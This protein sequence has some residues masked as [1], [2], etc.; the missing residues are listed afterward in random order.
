[1]YFGRDG[2]TL[3]ILLAGG[4]KRRERQDIAAAQ[5]RWADYRRRRKEGT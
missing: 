4:T 1:V 3:V 5:E 2:Q